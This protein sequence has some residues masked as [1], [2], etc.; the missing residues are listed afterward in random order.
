VHD[1]AG[2]VALLVAGRDARLHEW[3]LCGRQ[4]GR[5]AVPVSCREETAAPSRRLEAGSAGGRKRQGRKKK[6][7]PWFATQ[8]ATPCSIIETRENPRSKMV[9]RL[10]LQL[11]MI[12][13]VNSAIS[14]PILKYGTSFEDS[15]RDGGDDAGARYKGRVEGGAAR[16]RGGGGAHPG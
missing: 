3:H 8:R 4:G 2:A 6:Q 15:L 7:P 12:K 5:N 10:D 13:H 16:T 11:E 1:A 14:G 9:S